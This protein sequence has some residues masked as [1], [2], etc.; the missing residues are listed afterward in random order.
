M[1][2]TCVG[3]DS[4]ATS[5]RSRKEC[6]EQSA[7]STGHGLRKRQYMFAVPVLV[8]SQKVRLLYVR[9]DE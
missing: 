3:K 6:Y 5:G 2:A 7:L 4:D 9:K 8:Q 1:A